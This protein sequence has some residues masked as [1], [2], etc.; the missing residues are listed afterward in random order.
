[1][2]KYTPLWKYVK[3]IG[4]EALIMTFAGIENIAGV[5]VDHSFLRYKKELAEYGWRV[6]KISMKDR[7]VT[8][9]KT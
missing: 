6:A 3:N 9:E 5:P 7:T 2:S 1:M 4:D 8:F